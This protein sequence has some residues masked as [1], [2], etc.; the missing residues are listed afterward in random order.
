MASGSEW[1]ASRTGRDLREEPQLA[2]PYR[3]ERERVVRVWD[4][5]RQA[6]LDEIVT[7][8]IAEWSTS[9]PSEVTAESAVKYR[10]YSDWWYADTQMKSSLQSMV[11]HPAYL[12]IH[13]YGTSRNTV[14]P[15]RSSRPA[16][17]VVRSAVGNYG[18]R[19]GASRRFICGRDPEVDSLGP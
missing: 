2:H 18:G 19:S 5:R 12:R 6:K 13:R 3:R 16:R 17:A 15:P 1:L 9:R 7:R 10:K 4:A 11:L 14:Y 8:A